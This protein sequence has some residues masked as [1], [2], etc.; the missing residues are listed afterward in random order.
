MIA[1]DGEI[2]RGS[3]R[4]GAR[5]VRCELVRRD[6]RAYSRDLVVQAELWAGEFGTKW[7]SWERVVG[8]NKRGSSGEGVRPKFSSAWKRKMGV[9]DMLP[10][11][12]GSGFGSG[13]LTRAMSYGRAELPGLEKARRKGERAGHEEGEDEARWGSLAGKEW[14]MFEEGGF[15]GEGKKDF[16]S[17]L[18]FDLNESAKTVCLSLRLS[19]FIFPLPLFE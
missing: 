9:K 7:D 14:S 16:K 19:Y 12:S 3:P 5:V 2:A 11:P 4:R 8:R 15:G 10:L 17:K 1:S 13:D 18:Q 6:V